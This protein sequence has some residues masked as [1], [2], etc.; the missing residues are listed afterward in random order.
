[1]PGYKF[2]YNAALKANTE[3]EFLEKIKGKTFQFE[4]Q[5]QD[6][7]TKRYFTA[8]SKLAYRKEHE[9]VAWLLKVHPGYIN[10]V[11]EA[12]AMRGCFKQINKYKE[13]HYFPNTAI[14]YG[15]AVG[16]RHKKIEFYVKK[17]PTNPLIMDAIIKG[18]AIGGNKDM[19][20]YYYTKYMHN[21]HLPDIAQA[22]AEG[23][24]DNLVNSIWSQIHTYEFLEKNPNL[25]I[26]QFATNIAIGYARLGNNEKVEDFR[27]HGASVKSIADAYREIKN[28]EKLREYDL[29]TILETYLKERK[30]FRDSNNKTKKYKGLPLPFFQKSF[31]DKETA[32]NLLLQALRGKPVNLIPHL[33]TLR[34]G[35][36]GKEIRAFI[37][38]E[39]ANEL[40]SFPINSVSS[41]IKAL[42]KKITPKEDKDHKP[43]LF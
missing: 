28:Y 43:S 1:M 7:K 3:E 10:E 36:L 26:K 5:Q 9:K 32:V 39:K 23:G 22:Y 12:Y 34:N 15:A 30:D 29:S 37:K 16:N 25:S 11:I 8:A 24:H 17:Y 4:E 18:Y 38:A 19:V 6:K 31:K 35:T 41:F 14:A 42:Q 21:L 40:V 2:I 13:K 27:Y 33:S 20:D